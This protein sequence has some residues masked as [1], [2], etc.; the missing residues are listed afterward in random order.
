MDIRDS[1][2][3][4]DG[5][6][7]HLLKLLVFQPQQ[8]RIALD[9]RR[10]ALFHVDCIAA[11]RRELIDTCGTD[12]ARGLLTRM[13]YQSGVLDA[14]MV[15]RERHHSSLQD[16]F[17]AGPW[18]HMI[19]GKVIVEPVRFEIDVA[20]GHCYLEAIWRNSIEVECHTRFYGQAAAPVCWMEVG[21]AAGWASTF[22]GR[23]IL[24]REVEC[25]AAGD[26]QCRIVGQPV[27]AWGA[28]VGDLRYFQSEPFV[29][30]VTRWPQRRAVPDQHQSPPQTELVG[31]SP[32]FVAASHLVRKVAATRATV[33]FLGETGVGK[34]LFAENLHRVSDRSGGP[35]VAV[36][37]AAIPETLIEAELFGVEKGAYT[38]AV[39][40]RPGRFERAHGG[41]LFLDE[42]STLSLHAQGKLLHVLQTGKIERIGDTRT[43]SVDVRVIAATNEDLKARVE[44]GTFRR[45]LFYRLNVFPIRVPS[46]RDRREDLPLLIHHFLEQFADRYGKVIPGIG[47]RALRALLEHDYPGN[48][49]EL[50]NMMERA[51]IL[52]SDGAPLDEFSLFPGAEAHTRN[53]HAAPAFE[54]NG[55]LN[56]VKQGEWTV[57]GV[58]HALA[59]AALIEANG[60]IAAAARALGITRRKLAY[61]LAQATMVDA[62]N[63]E[64]PL[65]T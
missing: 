39:A 31:L 57:R 56:A 7:H 55:L 5:D 42:V 49:R 9:D 8:G 35:F 54:L 30:R 59:Q 21:R 26:A 29:N 11:L 47:E 62:K 14:E 20:R 3:G 64:R 4:I 17:S 53:D 25:R 51:V 13:G 16:A 24:C 23:T 34:G 60:N 32:G 46:L 1:S 28:D 41:S 36:N 38:G 61:R 65:S 2:V 33:L 45:D 43:R 48:I 19:E 18:L 50:E 15:R 40:S 52:C 44:Q 6:F 22:V 58:E 10:M 12:T 37:C 27:D 63:G